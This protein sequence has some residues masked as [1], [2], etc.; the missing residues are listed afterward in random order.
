MDMTLIKHDP[1][2][3]NPLE[4]GT[5]DDVAPAIWNGPHVGRRIAEAMR[6]LRALPG[7]GGGSSGNGWPPYEYTFEDLL[8]QQ[9]QGELEKTQKMQNRTR[10]SPSFNEVTRMEA[11]IWWP[12]RYLIDEP[13][14]LVAVNAVALAHSLEQDAGW[15]T[16][17]RG[18]Y[19]DTWRADHDRGCDLIAEGLILERAPVF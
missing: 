19:A 18:G 5:M 13:Y 9:E 14:L 7:G 3:F 17:K 11:A 10:L 1:I 12:A 15:V 16:T 8:A 4:D 2:K 6:T